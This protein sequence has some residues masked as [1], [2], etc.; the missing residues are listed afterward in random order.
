VNALIEI[1]PALAIAA[2]GVGLI[3]YAL[4]MALAAFGPGRQDSLA[5]RLRAWLLSAPAQNIGLPCAAI[6]AFAIVA[7]LLRAFPPSATGSGDFSFKAFGLEFNGPSG[8]ITLWLICFLAFVV[9]LRLAARM[10]R[11]GEEG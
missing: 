4:A 2:V 1:A 8:P 9:A 6:S 7:I 3:V 11:L 5:A 10:R